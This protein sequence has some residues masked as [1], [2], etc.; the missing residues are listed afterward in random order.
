MT[1][2]GRRDRRPAGRH[3]DRRRDRQRA[4][5]NGRIAEAICR[6]HLRLRGWRVLAC[7]WRCPVGEID[8]IARRGR[9]LAIVEVKTRGN[10]DIAAAA[11]V[12]RQRRRIVRATEAFLITRPELGE[13]DVRFDVML[14]DGRRLPRH[15]ASAWRSDTR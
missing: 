4:E 13:L 8:I 15:V 10:L 7:D 11:I 9:V 6:W 3:P 1:G 12:P 5:R 14:F 2:L